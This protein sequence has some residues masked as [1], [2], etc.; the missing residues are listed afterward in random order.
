M[1]ITSKVGR[2]TR[3][4]SVDAFCEVRRGK[5]PGT[6]EHFTT[7]LEDLD[8]AVR[9]EFPSVK[10]GALN[11]C[12]GD[13]YEWLVGITAWNY[14]IRKNSSLLL[15]HLPNKS[16]FDLAELYETDLLSHIRDLR[17][18]VEKA[19]GVKLITSNP[20]FVIIDSEGLELPDV[21]QI[22]Q[23]SST[24]IISLTSRYK[25][26]IGKCTF[27]SVLGY[28][29]VKTSMRPDRRL[30]LPHEGS[31]MKAVY[32]HLQTREWIIDPPG[33]KYYAAA[34]KIGDKDEE[35]LRTVATHSIV[36]VSSEPQ[37]A[38]DGVFAINSVRNTEKAL[39]KILSQSSQ[40]SR[41]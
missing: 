20:D 24:G 13:W 3:I 39:T 16:S 1:P 19:T 37:A 12:H 27:Q 26:L 15:L 38:V 35:A 30:Q 32:A 41:Q 14:S 10:Q 18:K 17:T 4:N 40:H 22:T 21:N 2:K 28:L 31:L 29:S 33:L 6:F 36:T 8:N 5:L 9:S 34:A 23:L 11:K 7:I 25:D